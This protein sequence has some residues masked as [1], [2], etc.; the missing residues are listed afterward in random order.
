MQRQDKNRSNHLN[1]AQVIAMS[2]VEDFIPSPGTIPACA[3]ARRQRGSMS[4]KKRRLMRRRIA[5]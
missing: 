5:R 2:A 4:Q 3:Y 1:L